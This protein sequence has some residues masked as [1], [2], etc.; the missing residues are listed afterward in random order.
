MTP[1][2]FLNQPRVLRDLIREHEGVLMMLQAQADGMTGIAYDK[3]PV[4]VSLVQSG[5]EEYIMRI[6]QL[7]Q[8]IEQNKRKFNIIYANVEKTIDKLTNEREIRVLKLRYL[9]FLDWKVIFAQMEETQD[10]VYSL[11]KRAL[12][13]I[14]C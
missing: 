7:K 3:E 8:S 11:H 2:E 4:K 13:H 1:K 10:V 14:R 12:N 6:E 5:T 9:M